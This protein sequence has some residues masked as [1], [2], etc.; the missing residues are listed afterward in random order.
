M[1]RW[2]ARLLPAGA[3]ILAAI[4]HELG[5]ELEV[6]AGGLREGAALELAEHLRAAARRQQAPVTAANTRWIDLVTTDASTVTD[7]DD[8]AL[9][10]AA[11]ATPFK[12]PENGLFRPGSHFEQFYFDETGDT[13]NQT[14]AGQTGG[15][16][17]IFRLKQDPTSR[18]GSISLFYLGDET[19]SAFDNTA[20][21]S[22]TQVAFVEDAGDT[23]HG[24]RNALDSGW[25]FDATANYANSS[26]KPTR[27]LAQGRDASATLDSSISSLYTS[28]GFYNDGDNEI[29]GTT[30]SDG[31]PGKDGV[32]GAR[33]PKPF[34]GE[35]KWRAFYTQQHGDNVTYELIR[36]GTRGDG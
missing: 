27:F 26:A 25:L 12:R 18:D 14:T 17:G 32:L 7:P 2:R 34:R 35:G 19:H 16:G 6:A 33:I 13:N 15:F 22:D 9:A 11:H 24:Q 30:V 21:L 10:K 4:Q 29:T 20:W 1:P 8:N 5:I 36:A 3:T 28:P 23:L 31:D